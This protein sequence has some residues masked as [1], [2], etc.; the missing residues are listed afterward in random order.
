[1]NFLIKITAFASAVI[2][3]GGCDNRPNRTLSPPPE[4]KWVNVTFRGQEGITLQPAELLYRSERCKSVRYNSSNEPHDIPGYNDIEQ[5]FS[6]PE[7]NDIWQLRVVVDGGGSCQ[8]RLNSL[9][10]SFKIADNHPLAK[11]KKIIDTSYIFDF[12]DY[13]LSDGYGT[14]RAKVMSGDLDLKTDLFPEIFISHLFK[15]ETLE[16][17]G[18]D[19]RYEQFTRRYRLNDTQNIVI[20]P[21]VH[22]NQV[23]ILEGPNPRPGKISATYPDGSSEEITG[24]KPDYEKLLTMK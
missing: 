8:W 18:G 2:F 13:G 21:S 6:S 22:L 1:M 7:G 4:A 5:P 20:D 19:T 10:V 14:G 15:E 16:L 17:F 23:V 12:G 9:M 24:T 3:L 11:G